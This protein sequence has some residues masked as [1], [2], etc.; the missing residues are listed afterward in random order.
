MT[1]FRT[2]PV[3]TQLTNL[4]KSL[5]F[6][7]GLNAC[8][9]GKYAGY[10]VNM[11]IPEIAVD[12]IKADLADRPNNETYLEVANNYAIVSVS[13]A[14]EV[15]NQS[16]GEVINYEPS[17]LLIPKTHIGKIQFDTTAWES[18]AVK[19]VAVDEMAS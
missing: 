18:L 7:H 15:L 6:G 12:I 2:S 8:K 14:K 9:S 19:P 17:V 16:T 13:E 5:A 11:R 3:S 4:F 1:Q 10:G